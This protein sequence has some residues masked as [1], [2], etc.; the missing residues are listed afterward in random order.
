MK[1]ENI[2]AFGSAWSQMSEL[3]TGREVSQGAQVMAFEIFKSYDLDAVLNAMGEHMTGNKWMPSPSEIIN[4]LEGAPLTAE[5]LI[6]MARSD[7]LT[8]LGSYVRQ[9]VTPFSLNTWELPQLL[10]YIKTLRPEIDAFMSDYENGNLS[11]T[12]K[13]L[14]TASGHDCTEPLRKPLGERVTAP[15]VEYKPNPEGQARV[16]ALTQ[17][18]AASV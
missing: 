1:P 18:M 17:S 9:R 5:E 16:K 14:L 3:L 11:A 2:E 7:T 13:R 4:L 6:G 10:A 15:A 8:I 12:D